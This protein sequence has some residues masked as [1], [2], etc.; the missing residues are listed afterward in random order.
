MRLMRLMGL[1]RWMLL[2][3]ALA[4]LT[5]LTFGQQ[6]PAP[7]CKVTPVAT[8]NWVVTREGARLYSVTANN[9]GASA[10]YLFVVNTNTTAA[11][12][13]ALPALPA[14]LIPTTYTGGYDF[15]N[16]G[17]TFSSG[18]VVC[19]SSTADTL[20]LDGASLIIAVNYSK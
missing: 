15:Q 17:F 6:G 1:M 2:G 8:N 14:V 13:G 3:L 10:V 4:C 18:L 16:V 9:I 11:V 20:T 12:N 5:P 7:T 19:A